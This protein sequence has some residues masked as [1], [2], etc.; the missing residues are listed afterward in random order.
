M[1]AG[2]IVT[3]S[4]YNRSAQAAVSTQRYSHVKDHTVPVSFAAHIDQPVVYV[5]IFPRVAQRLSLCLR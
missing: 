4:F 1:P 2:E 3:S 5:V